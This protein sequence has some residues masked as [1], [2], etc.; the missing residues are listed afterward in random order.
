VQ[1]IAKR[2]GLAPADVQ[3]VVD[4]VPAALQ[5]MPDTRGPAAQLH[6][7]GHPLYFL[8]N[9]PAP[10]SASGNAP[11]TASSSMT[12]RPTSQWRASSG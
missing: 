4:A 3:A 6:A 5:P 8:S 2:T 12:T 7:A 9:M 1:R 11:R 10:C